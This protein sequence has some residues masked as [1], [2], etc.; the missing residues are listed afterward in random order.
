MVTLGRPILAEIDRDADQA[1]PEPVTDG[2]GD[3]SRFVKPDWTIPKESNKPM[4]FLRI[5]KYCFSGCS[6]AS[7]TQQTRGAV[8]DF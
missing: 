1:P 2:D 4:E 3:A 5:G 8:R 6:H 7:S